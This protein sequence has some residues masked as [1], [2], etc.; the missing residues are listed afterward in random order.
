VLRR[1]HRRDGSTG[2]HCQCHP[3]KRR[4]IP[5]K[6]ITGPGSEDWFYSVAKNDSGMT[7][8]YFPVL[9]FFPESG[10]MTKYDFGTSAKNEKG[11]DRQS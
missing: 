5:P 7:G 8:G 2:G 9:T 11:P 6:E 4:N 10:I 1:D 3:R